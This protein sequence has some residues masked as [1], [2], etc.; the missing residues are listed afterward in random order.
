MAGGR[1]QAA[2]VA[3]R[4]LLGVGA[5]CLAGWWAWQA[6]FT[7]LQA[8]RPAAEEERN[9]W[10]RLVNVAGCNVPGANH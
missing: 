1:G 9:V 3:T 4:A 5:G 8:V 10:H 7:A 6:V 2:V